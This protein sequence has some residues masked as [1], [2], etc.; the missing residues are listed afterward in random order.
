M[1]RRVVITGIGAVTPVG[2][3]AE[4]FW[5]SLLQGKSGTGPLTALD[6]TPY[7]SKVAAEVK[8]FDPTQYMPPKAA[9]KSDRFVHFA[10]AGS[11]M[12]V[13]DSGLDVEAVEKERAGVLIGSGIGG[14]HTV[15]KQHNSCSLNVRQCLHWLIGGR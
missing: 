14:L 15:E 3:T 6:S 7:T 10:M 12:A 2:N 4:D 1:N 5:S 11:V 9:R 13:K 8:D